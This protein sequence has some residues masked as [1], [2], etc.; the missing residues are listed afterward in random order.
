LRIG[1]IVI[2]LFENSPNKIIMAKYITFVLLTGLGLIFISSPLQAQNIGINSSGSTPDVS[3]LLD[4]S[5]TSKGLLIPRVSLT[6]LTDVSTIATPAT[7]LLVYNTNVSLSGRTGYYYNAG[8]TTAASWV[9]LVVTDATG[10][11]KSTLPSTEVVALDRF[12]MGEVSMSSNT[13]ATTI[14]AANTFYKVAGTTSLSTGSYNFTNGGVSNRLTYTGT[15]N[16][17][18]H[19]AC[20]LSASSGSNNQTVKAVVYKNG[21]ALTT[22]IIQFKLFQ[23]GE[24]GSATIIVMIDLAP[25]DYLELRIQNISGAK[26]V[27]V[28]EMNMF[29]MGVSMGLD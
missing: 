23:A 27:T 19:I 7:S 14:S 15:K 4:V 20:T 16:K 25:N 26:N 12:P 18:F 13:T 8:T 24:I 6:S 11:V 22:G 10:V 28:T 2:S 5:G 21:T 17:M 1:I 29:A 9:R 3:A